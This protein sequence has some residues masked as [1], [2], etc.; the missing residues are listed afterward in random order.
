MDA[1]TTP[2]IPEIKADTAPVMT[3]GPV[4]SMVLWHA[5]RLHMV[6]QYSSSNVIRQATIYDFAKTPESVPDEVVLR[7][8]SGDLWRD[9]SEEVRTIE[10]AS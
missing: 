5:N 4:G 10:A 8:P 7:D 9:W 3:V 2:S 1:R 6:G